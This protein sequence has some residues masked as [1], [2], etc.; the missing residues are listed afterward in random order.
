LKS[1]KWEE[2]KNQPKLRIELIGHTIGRTFKS[3]K[4]KEKEK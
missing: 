2:N 3:K 1:N 4:G